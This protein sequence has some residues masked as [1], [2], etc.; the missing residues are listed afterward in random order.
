MSSILIREKKIGTQYYE[1]LWEKDK[2]YVVRKNGYIANHYGGISKANALKR[3]SSKLYNIR[4][5]K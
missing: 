3:F 2:G 5:S 4:K 1:L